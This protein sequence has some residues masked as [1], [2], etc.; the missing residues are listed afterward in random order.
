MRKEYRTV[1]T[2]RYP[3]SCKSY[4]AESRP[5]GIILGVHGF[6]GDKE[7]SALR[8]LAAA[9][10]EKGISLI[11]FDFPAH[12]ASEVQADELTVKNCMDDLCVL[13]DLCRREHP[14]EKKYLF[15]TSFGGYIALLC[16]QKLTDFNIVLRAPAVT[17]PEHI[18]TDLLCTTPERYKQIGAMICGFERE[19]NLPYR[20]YEELQEHRLSDCICDNPMLMI[21]GDKD[22]VVPYQ[23][24]IA[25]CSAHKNVEL[26]V[27]Q[28][29]DHR[30]KK[31]GEIDRV[32]ELT[33]SYW[34]L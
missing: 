5:S 1:A 15:A 20:F 29:A 17:M 31:S 7:S 11:C 26:R 24:V 32:I 28:G 22:D 21:H 2:D 25:F 10:T 23:D 6:A 8:A 13:A 19:I 4:V 9:S 18:L 34:G 14:N 30:F 16:S 12:G 33:L 27:M 3:I